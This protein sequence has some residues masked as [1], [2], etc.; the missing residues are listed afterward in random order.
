MYYVEEQEGQDTNIDIGQYPVATPLVTSMRPR[1]RVLDL[2][3]RE[4]KNGREEVRAR[5]TRGRTIYE[6][7]RERERKKE[8]KGERGEE[9]EGR[10][11][12]RR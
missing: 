11:R 9:R 3:A 1:T 7:P 10:E 12:E 8:K 2:G 5:S 4:T 6:Q